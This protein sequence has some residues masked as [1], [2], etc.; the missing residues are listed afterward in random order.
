MSV[1]AGPSKNQLNLPWGDDMYQSLPAQAVGSAVPSCTFDHEN[2]QVSRRDVVQVFPSRHMGVIVSCYVSRRPI[3]LIHL[4]KG[5][6]PDV[7]GAAN[8]GRDGTGATSA[9]HR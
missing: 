3:D 5:R 1:L 8:A 9:R 6:T 4:L 7:A 2:S